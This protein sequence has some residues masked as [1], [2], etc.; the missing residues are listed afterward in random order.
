MLADLE[1]AFAE[2]FGARH[3]IGVSNEMAAQFRR[4]ETKSTTSATQSP[5]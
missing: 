1:R 5:R 3:A 4:L 2:R